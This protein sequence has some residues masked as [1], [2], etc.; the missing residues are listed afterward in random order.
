M[1][2]RPRRTWR[3]V[4]YYAIGSTPRTLRLIAILVV[5][6]LLL[7]DR[8]EAEHLLRQ[9]EQRPVPVQL[10]NSRVRVADLTEDTLPSEP[11]KPPE[12]ARVPIFT[13]AEWT[14][15]VPGVLALP[16]GH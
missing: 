11:A 13:H 8:A 5:I 1:P 15:S 2:S 12:I 7:P 16:D 6:L 4:V 14:T 3:D 10:T 9:L